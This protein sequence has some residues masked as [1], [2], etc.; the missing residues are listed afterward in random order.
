MSALAAALSPA[1]KPDTAAA[2]CFHCGET[3]PAAAIATRVGPC[4]QR[5]CCAGCAAAASWIDGAGLDDYYRLRTTHSQRVAVD[6]SDLAAWDS[7][8]VLKV[9]AREVGDGREIVLASD[10]MHCAACAWLIDR[11]LART[12]G[13]REVS[14][15]AVTGR[16]RLIWDPT[17]R[18]STILARLQSLG[19]RPYLA[20]GVDAERARQREQRQWLLRLGIAGIVALQAM[21]LTEALYLDTRG[22]MP[23]P[24]RDFFRW[25]T[26]LLATPV[27][28]YAGFPFLAGA[29][30]ELRMRRA[31]MDTLVAASTLLALG[32]Q[33]LADA[34]RWHAGLVRRRR[35]VRVPAAGGALA[36]GTCAPAGAH[37]H[38]RA[39][40][41]AARAGTA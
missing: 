38:R 29:W 2:V 6:A 7:E 39:G 34:A 24:T 17:R 5:F 15:N 14:A 10:G 18:L 20:G 33:H 23:A 25:L 12:P 37:P 36:G 41:R 19:F 1:A 35:H 30:R 32:C 4:V 13:V 31:G 9:H 40:A 11:A 27:V 3:L 26:F 21:M 22:Q 16:I 28:F 8:E